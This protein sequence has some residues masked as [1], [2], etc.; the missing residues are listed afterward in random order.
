[1]P[2]P[3]ASVGPSFPL[4]RSCPFWLVDR[5]SPPLAELLILNVVAA[6]VGFYLAFGDKAHGDSG[7]RLEALLLLA[8][9]LAGHAGMGASQF[10]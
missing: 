9:A 2:I 4:P 6:W 8:L 3:H 7:Y 5:L 1:M 10:R